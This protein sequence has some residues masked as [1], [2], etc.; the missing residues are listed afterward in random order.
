MGKHQID[1]EG[2]R[3]DIYPSF[4]HFPRI[5]HHNH[6]SSYLFSLTR[7]VSITYTT[8]SMVTLVS[9]I[10]VLTTILRVPRGGTRNT[11][12]CSAED[13]E[14]C[15]GRIHTCTQTDRR[16]DT[17]AN[18]Q[19]DRRTGKQVEGSGEGQCRHQTENPCF[20]RSADRSQSHGAVGGSVGQQRTAKV[21]QRVI[22]GGSKVIEGGSKA[23]AA[24]ST[25]IAPH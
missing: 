13:S 6:T 19:T 3:K 1:S 16:T 15:S 9:A 11:R 23:S 10:L 7:H 18:K 14:E 17:Q 12:L 22:K 24:S 25:V 2:E 5:P 4:H 20:N 8:S 21:D